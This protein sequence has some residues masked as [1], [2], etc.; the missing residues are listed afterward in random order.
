MW[1]LLRPRIVCQTVWD[2]DVEGLKDKGIKTVLVDLDNTL[3]EWRK[4]QCTPQIEAWVN[5]VKQA[6]LDVCIVSNSRCCAEVADFAT[7]LGIRA[8]TRAG[9]P[10]RAGFRKALS[11][12]ACDPCHTAVIGDQV[13]TDVLG[14][15]R[16]GCYT[17][18]VRPLATR[19]FFGTKLVRVIESMILRWL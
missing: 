13:F 2:V 17:V 18:L 8:V 16:M 1:N 4:Y 7:R 9:K 11:M 19:E 12:I 15:N 5:R 14:G 6:G 10:R 3:V